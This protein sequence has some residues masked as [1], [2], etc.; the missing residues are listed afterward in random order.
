MSQTE[1]QEVKRDHVIETM[2]QAIAEEPAGSLGVFDLPCGFLDEDGVLHKEV[3]VREITGHEEDMLGSNSVPNHKKIGLLITGCLQRVGTITDQKTLNAVADNL[4]VCDRV[5]L[6]FAIRRA[7]LGDA[8]PFRSECPKCKYRGI[9]TL[10]LSDLEVKTMKEPMKRIFDCRLPS[11]KEARFRPLIGKDEER[12]SKASSS[13]EAL[14]LAI[15][16]RLLV[17]EGEPPTLKA[18]KDLGMKDRNFLRGEFDKVE[19]GIET[20]LDMGCPTCEHE[21]EEELDVSQ[22]G[23][24]FPSSVPKD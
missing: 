5:F 9:F 4:T 14:S 17:L 8:Y 21:F 24:F 20:T 16:M 18:V 7:S 2:Q 10:D 6:M 13:N 12:L 11:G 19:G 15:L 1:E 23:F 3:Q 22:A